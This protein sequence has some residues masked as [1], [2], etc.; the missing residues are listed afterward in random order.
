VDGNII[1]LPEVQRRYQDLVRA[2]DIVVTKPGYGI[3]ADCIA[4]QV[5]M[6]YTDR[7]NFPEYPLLVEALAECATANFIPQTDLFAGSLDTYLMQ[8]IEKTPN[9]PAVEL[10]GAEIAAEKIIRLVDR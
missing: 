7:G 2:V 10:N 6:L 9:W 4:H 8:L 1:A 3:V 5:P